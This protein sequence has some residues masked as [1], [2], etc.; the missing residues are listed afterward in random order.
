MARYRATL[1]YDG[2]AYFGFQRQAGATPTIQAAV[3][4]A[5]A[6]VLGQPTA[7]IGA[8][9]TDAGVHAT[10]QVIAFDAAWRHTAWQL[11][12]AVNANLPHDIA[13]QDIAQHAGFHPRYDAKSRRYRYDVL[14]TP[15]H[16]PLMRCRAWQVY[17]SRPL[18]LDAMRVAADSLLGQHDFATFGK[19]PEGNNTRR[20]VFQSRW[21]SQPVLRG[22]LHSYSIEAT[23]FLHHMVRRI[24]AMLVQVGIGLQSVASFIA[25]FERAQLAEALPLAPPHGLYLVAVRYHEPIVVNE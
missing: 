5:L 8:G 17:R 13:L 10:G 21:L 14:E 25:A 24:V 1:A 4:T 9:R 7:I 16:Q 20:E 18:A 23:A 11:L 19:P 6:R 22:I 2:S 3:E 12:R 15:V